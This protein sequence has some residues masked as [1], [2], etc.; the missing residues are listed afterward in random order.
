V[1]EDTEEQKLLRGAALKN[2]ESILIARQRAERELI[3][4]NESL[5]RHAVDLQQQCEW[6]A[7]TLSS[8]GDAVIT[9]DLQSNVTFLN[10]I[11]ETMTGWTAAEA[12]R[13]PLER[14]FRAINADTG[15]AVQDPVSQVLRSGQSVGFAN[16]TTLICRDGTVTSIAGGAAPIRHSTG[17]VIGAVMVF[18]DITQHRQAE[19]ALRASEEQLRAMFDQAAVGIAVSGL[20]NRFQEANLKFSEM[21]GYSLDELR[22]LTF[23]DITH[24]EDLSRTQVQARRLLAQEIPQYVLEKRYVRKDGTTVWSR[25][26]VKLLK[27]AAGSAIKFIG[28]V[29]D[30][31]D[32]KNTEQ[33]LREE[34]RVLELLNTTGSSIA[35]QLDLQT[36]LQTVTHAA[37]ELSGARFGALFFKVVNQ[38]GETLKLCA[39]SCAP[40]E[41][42]E[43]F[44]IPRNTPLFKPTF[45]GE[46]AFRSADVTQEPLYGT[47]SPDRGLPKGHLPVRSYLAVPVI[48]RSGEVIGV[49]LLGHPQVNVF[50]DRAE[51]LVL[52]VAAQAAV[53]IDN[54]RLYEAAQ[55]ELASRK[56]AESALRELLGAET[57]RT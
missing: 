3:A 18:H 54:A 33:A 10:P 17:D 31:T 6:F 14:V 23:T 42:F 5:Q 2:A 53:A 47:M 26:T 52:G 16:H 4:A 28:I 25:S 37:T 24:A 40:R 1:G 48:S 22:A 32:R 13:V 34:T 19:V 30:I 55:R 56:R 46:G 9:T 27:D 35:S 36:L 20:D 15:Q 51:R 41:A 57:P 45:R 21:L 11:A 8:I 12:R 49:L 50:T 7:V 44:D 29:E 39:L 43:K 38:D